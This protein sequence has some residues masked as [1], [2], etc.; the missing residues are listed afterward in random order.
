MLALGEQNLPDAFE[1]KPALTRD[2]VDAYA[3]ELREQDALS[4]IERAYG[5]LITHLRRELR[6]DS[7][8]SVH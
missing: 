2:E 6:G 4:A 8:K 7:R 5:D 3:A 1:R